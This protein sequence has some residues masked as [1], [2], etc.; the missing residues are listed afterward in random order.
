MITVRPSKERGHFDHGWLD[1]HHTFSFGDYRDP[2][3]MG[4][5]GLRVLNE[6][7]VQP[8]A[9]FPTHAH[10]DMEILTYVVS[11]AL[12]HKDSMGTG[13]VIR[14]GEMQ[15][16]SAGNGVTHSEY[17]ASRTEP[18]HFLQIWVIPDRRG[19]APQY[20]QKVFTESERLGKFRV[21]ASPDGGAGSVR[22]NADVR[23]Y[24]SLLELGAI[25]A[26]KIPEDRFGW[27]Q[28]VRGRVFLNDD[29][30]IS[31]GDGAALSNEET[32]HIMGDAPTGER[33]EILF[34]DL[35]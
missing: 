29:T 24:D 34:F 16:M 19:V 15:R 31:A 17:N 10:A 11:G 7:V 3:H 9:G 14:P 20:E 27:V 32:V 26:H 33:S 5:R 25:V 22:I 30:Q 28:V 2:A 13:S 18:V 8:G 6:D 21:I 12:E 23:I 1:T 4:F 35:A